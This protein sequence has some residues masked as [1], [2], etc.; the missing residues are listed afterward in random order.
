MGEGE[1]LA[2]RLAVAAVAGHYVLLVS[3]R[4]G[5]PDDVPTL[6][7]PP[8]SAVAIGVTLGGVGCADVVGATA[9]HAVTD[10]LVQ[11]QRDVTA[12]P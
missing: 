12:G 11:G 4:L 1:D 6:R 10:D 5:L 2:V 8:G 3:R 9:Q 7:A